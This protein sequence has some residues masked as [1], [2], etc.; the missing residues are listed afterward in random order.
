M[1]DKYLAGWLLDG[2]LHMIA[3]EPRGKKALAAHNKLVQRVLGGPVVWINLRTRAV[4]SFNPHVFGYPEVPMQNAQISAT[5][6]ALLKFVDG[7]S[8]LPDVSPKYSDG[9]ELR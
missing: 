1:S 8:H 4:A 5:V 7:T 6:R 2:N 3:E 9:T